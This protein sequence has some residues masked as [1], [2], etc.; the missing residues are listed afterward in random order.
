MVRDKYVF[1]SLR[2]G[3]KTINVPS[4]MRGVK[5]KKSLFNIFVR[6]P[7]LDRMNL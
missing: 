6:K 3:S 2:A 1:Y 4:Q 7:N 5:K